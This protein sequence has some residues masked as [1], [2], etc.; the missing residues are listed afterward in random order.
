VCSC[1]CVCFKRACAVFVFCAFMCL[2]VA[3]KC[4]LLSSLKL[5]GLPSAFAF[6][7]A[8]AA[9]APFYR[10]IAAVDLNSRTSYPRRGVPRTVGGR[11]LHWLRSRGPQPRGWGR[12]ALAREDTTLD[13]G[14]VCFFVCGFLFPRCVLLSPPKCV[15]LSS[16]SGLRPFLT[17]PANL[18]Y[19]FILY[20]LHLRIISR[21]RA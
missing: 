19:C 13:L 10:A 21:C 7:R 20:A 1:V 14:C 16:P 17:P 4:V 2:S 18:A 12:E 3:L 9:C 6:Y 8:I 15:L 11:S 5:G